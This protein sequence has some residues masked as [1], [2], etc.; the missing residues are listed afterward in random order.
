MVNHHG[1]SVPKQA[2]D[3]RYNRSGASSESFLQRSIRMGLHN[4]ID[5]NFPLGHRNTPFF[6]QVDN[7]STRDTLQNAAAKARRDH[8]AVDLEKDVHTAHFFQILLLN[9]VEPQHLRAVM[10]FGQ[11]LR[12][13]AACVIAGC[14]GDTRPTLNRPRIIALD[15]GC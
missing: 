2:A 9:R 14:F 6:Q 7:A 5:R 1:R 4:V 10:R 8:F 11:R 12:L 13:Q 3:W 15:Q